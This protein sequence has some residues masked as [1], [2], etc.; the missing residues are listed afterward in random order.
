MAFSSDRAGYSG[1]DCGSFQGQPRLSLPI[2][3]EPRMAAYA[4]WTA[5]VIDQG[6]NR[7]AELK[8]AK[9]KG[10]E[11][12]AAPWRRQTG[13]VFRGYRSALDGSVQPYRVLLPR[14]YPD[15]PPDTK[16]GAKLWRLDL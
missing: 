4:K 7:A 5:P 11:A 6:L 2:T 3:M 13:T 9:T 16:P 14:D 12:G 8:S 15:G 10:N 1:A